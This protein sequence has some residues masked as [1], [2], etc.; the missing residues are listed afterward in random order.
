MAVSVLSKR[1]MVP[2]SV[3]KAVCSFPFGFLRGAGREMGGERE[4]GERR[5]ES[6]T[7]CA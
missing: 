7:L 1:L 6:W 3:I 2:V 5:M 4:M